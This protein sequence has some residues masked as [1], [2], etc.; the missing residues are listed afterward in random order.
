MRIPTPGCV[1]VEQ[2]QCI[3][4]SEAGL[5]GDG[6]DNDCN[7]LADMADPACRSGR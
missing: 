7:G 2:L 5:C 6:I 4:T 1:Q 3:K